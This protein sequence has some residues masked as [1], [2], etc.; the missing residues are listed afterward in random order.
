MKMI[1]NDGDAQLLRKFLGVENN[2]KTK[3]DIS[4]D[5]SVD[6]SSCIFQCSIGAGS[7]V[8][9][10]VL[11]CVNSPAINATD[12]ICVNVTAKKI[13]CSGGGA[14]VYNIVDES[15]EGLTLGEGD[16]LVGV[17]NAKGECIRLKSNVSIDGGKVWK[18]I[19][20]GNGMSFEDTMNANKGSDVSSI[21]KLRIAAHAT[22]AAVTK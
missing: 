13:N 11:S 10:S 20:E 14:I 12:A 15:E 2:R 4:K 9:K 6:E 5:A 17:W 8:T 16:V 19:L 22:A 7:S 21:E 3:S 18:D 1:E